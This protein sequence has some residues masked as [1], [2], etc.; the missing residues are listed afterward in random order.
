[1]IDRPP[2]F[3]MC[4]FGSMRTTG[5]SVRAINALSRRLSRINIE[6]TCMRLSVFVSGIGVLVC[7]DDRSHIFALERTREISFDEPVD[8]LN[9]SAA[10]RMLHEIEHCALY[11]DI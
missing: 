4:A 5:D 11:D 8:H 7:C 9:R 6:L 2:I 3:T 10:L 1:M